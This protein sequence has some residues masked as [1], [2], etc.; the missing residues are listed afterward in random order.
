MH[1]MNRQ[2]RMLRSWT[3]AFQLAKDPGSRGSSRLLAFCQSVPNCG[4]HVVAPRER[5]Q[6]NEARAAC[7]ACGVGHGL[8]TGV[9]Q[10]DSMVYL[11]GVT[12]RVR[13]RS[14]G[15]SLAGLVQEALSLA[16]PMTLPPR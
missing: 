13:V 2:R 15:K 7:S 16:G 6:T 12:G 10:D 5:L 3:G 1:E 8:H 14:P 9:L 4:H 11:T